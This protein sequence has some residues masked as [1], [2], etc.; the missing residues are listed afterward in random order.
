MKKK[1]EEIEECYNQIEKLN[2]ELISKNK[3]TLQNQK[4]PSDLSEKLQKELENAQ[5][6]QSE[7]NKT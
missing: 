7:L 3:E 5:K 2:A 4:D 1:I 6:L